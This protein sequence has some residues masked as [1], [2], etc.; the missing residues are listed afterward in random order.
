M[1]EERDAAGDSAAPAGDCDDDINNT[2]FFVRRVDG[3]VG[4]DDGRI[5]LSSNNDYLVFDIIED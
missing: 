2:F 3:G 1:Q 4:G 5:T